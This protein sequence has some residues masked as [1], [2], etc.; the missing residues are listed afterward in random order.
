MSI[1]AAQSAAL[2][3]STTLLPKRRTPKLGLGGWRPVMYSIEVRKQ[4]TGG[5]AVKIGVFVVKGMACEHCSR[6]VEQA[7]CDLPGVQRAA[8]DFGTGKVT[9]EM[10]ANVALSDIRA[11]VEEAGYELVR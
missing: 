5:T 7:L 8:A 1:L 2:S 11:A 3:Q 10:D 4:G 9:V 6:A